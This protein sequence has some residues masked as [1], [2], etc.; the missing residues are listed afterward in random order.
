MSAAGHSRRFGHVRTV[1]ALPLTADHP[2]SPC[3][4]RDGLCTRTPSASSPEPHPTPCS[5]AST[6]SASSSATPD[7]PDGC[8]SPKPLARPW[9]SIR[10]EGSLGCQRRPRMTPRAVSEFLEGLLA[11]DVTVFSSAVGFRY[12]RLSCLWRCL[13]REHGDHLAALL[14]LLRLEPKPIFLRL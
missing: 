2:R 11:M 1:S 14:L 7:S 8:R 5:G 9:S 4:R 10:S 6:P 13:R 12:G 3:K